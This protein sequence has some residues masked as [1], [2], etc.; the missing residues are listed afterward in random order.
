MIELVFT[1]VLVALAFPP[2]LN[3]FVHT[4]RSSARPDLQVA[5]MNLARE[6]MEI[7]AADKFTPARG[8]AYLTAANYPDETPVTG[9]LF[10]RSVAFTDVASSDLSTAQSG[11]GY[12]KV[13]V[14]VSWQNGGERLTLSGV[15]T[16]H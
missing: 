2:L 10:N 3:V 8:Y 11:S 6:K 16:D 9:F 13:V 14:T 4:G 15:F 5:A 7:L 12:R 1:I